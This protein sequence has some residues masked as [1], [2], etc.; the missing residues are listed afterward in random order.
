MRRSLFSVALLLPLIAAGQPQKAELD[1][2]ARLTLEQR[3]EA[4][5]RSLETVAR[6]SGN[7]REVMLRLFEL[8][9]V[10]FAQLA[11]E[12]KARAAFRQLLSLDPQRELNGKYTGRV[13]KIFQEA[14]AWSQENGGLELLA[15]AAAL[16][17][18]GKVQQIAV[19]V[20]NDALKLGRK[21]R[22][23]VRPQDG[24][25]GEL[26]G[27]LQGPYASVGTEADGVE[28][29]A[30]LLGERDAVLAQV[31]SPKSPVR[32]GSMKEKAP[33]VREVPAPLAEKPDRAPTL[34]PRPDPV[35]EPEVVPRSEPAASGNEG[36]RAVGY[37]ALVLGMASL[38]AGTV[39]GG[40]WRA[41]KS[42]VDGRLSRASL[43]SQGRI[44][45]I[46]GV[47]SAPQQWYEGM[48]NRL[49]TQAVCANVLWGAGG[50]LAIA[51]LV[52]VLLGREVA[53][54]SPGSGGLVIAW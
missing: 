30:E 50:G 8:Q 11:Q 10:V 45:R 54:V 41:T 24:K 52:M 29:F 48:K 4:A 18:K 25:W 7:K 42:D 47:E 9:G 38:V 16:D 14:Q 27:E 51:G 44:A 6:Q 53:D 2:A 1:K 26:D 33:V 28:W 12:A 46:E 31:G 13:M 19:K 34:E 36:L 5:A 39:M 32:E 20:K 49:A 15:E 40:V 17:A 21:V 3:Y 43:D 22:F 37:S 35:H 23:T